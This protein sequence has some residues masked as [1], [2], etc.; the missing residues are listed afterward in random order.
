MR[1]LR[2]SPEAGR[3]PRTADHDHNQ[4]LAPLR[5]APR[6]PLGARLHGGHARG[7]HRPAKRRGQA[8]S[9]TDGE[10]G[11]VLPLI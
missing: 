11:S 4:D 3:L 2:L 6:Y 10:I 1:T 7:W 5:R 9:H 8:S